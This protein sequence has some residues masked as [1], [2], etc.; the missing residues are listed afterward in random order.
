MA[1]LAVNTNGDRLTE[2]FTITETTDKIYT[3]SS[4]F[5]LVEE[6]DVDLTIDIVYT[7]YFDLL[8]FPTFYHNTLYADGVNG[9]SSTEGRIVKSPANIYFDETE[10]T[11]K[12]NDENGTVT[13]YIDSF[14]S[15][16]NYMHDLI[17]MY[18]RFLVAVN[19]DT[20]DLTK[21]FL[22][23]NYA[24]CFIKNDYDAVITN[25]KATAK[26]VNVVN[27]I[28]DRTGLYPIFVKENPDNVLYYDDYFGVSYNEYPLNYNFAFLLIYDDVEIKDSEQFGDEIAQLQQLMTKI[29]VIQ[30]YNCAKDSNANLTIVSFRACS[31]FTSCN[32]FSDIDEYDLFNKHYLPKN[33]EPRTLQFDSSEWGQFINKSTKLDGSVD[34][35]KTNKSN[36]YLVTPTSGISIGT[37]QLD[38][39]SIKL[40][41]D[42]PFYS[43]F[44]QNLGG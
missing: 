11:I 16:N 26:N 19:W 15:I 4:N 9:G 44:T 21:S 43:G 40:P 34:T 32:Y 1:C 41:T 30:N 10:M 39:L 25:L 36:Y 13:F 42:L 29:D 6:P 28:T 17:N 7:P 31:L 38:S 2:D 20:F 18:K 5:T 22:Y 3:V 37:S 12:P 23:K 24:P 33:E 27:N 35:D 8:F 14:E